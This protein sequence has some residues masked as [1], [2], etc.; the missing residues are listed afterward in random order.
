MEDTEQGIDTPMLEAFEG[1]QRERRGGGGHQ[2]GP[3][4][5]WETEGWRWDSAQWAP[6]PL[7]SYQLE[8]I[9]R[10]VNRDHITQAQGLTGGGE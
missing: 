6:S 7:G 10:D 5:Q 2:A 9:G 3:A 8:Q 1:T 4:G